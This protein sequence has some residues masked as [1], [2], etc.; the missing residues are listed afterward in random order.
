[1]RMLEYLG[2]RETAVHRTLPMAGAGGE[3]LYEL[4]RVTF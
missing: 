1:M 3:G 2:L 4:R